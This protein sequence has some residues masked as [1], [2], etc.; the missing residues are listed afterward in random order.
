MTA[1]EAHCRLYLTVTVGSDTTASLDAALSAGDVA[2]LLLSGPDVAG[3][4]AA[5]LTRL[6][7]S[8]GVAVL[9]ED[10]I[11]AARSVGADGVHIAADQD[12]FEEAREALGNEAIIGVA[13]GRSKHEAMWFA[14]R[15]A[16]YIAFEPG[17]DQLAMIAWWAELFEIPCVAWQVDDKTHGLELAGRG[18]DFLA[19]TPE[20]WMPAGSSAETAVKD[21]N[22]ALA[23]VKSAA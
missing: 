22:A 21:W 15:G 1:N 8:M 9:V 4:D 14:E 17:E 18:A 13:C 12:R 7:Q 6:A 2:C 19:L 16:A 23:Q 3:K 11:A 20:A 10:D 5:D